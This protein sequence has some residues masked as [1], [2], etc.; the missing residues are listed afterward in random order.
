MIG[1][2]L[3][4]LGSQENQNLTKSYLLADSAG[5]CLG[6]RM[7]CLA[8][9]T[10]KSGAVDSRVS[11]KG[12]CKMSLSLRICAG[13]G[14]LRVIATGEFSLEEAERTFLEILAAVARHKAK[15][16]LLDGRAV[17]GEPKSIQRFL[18]GDFVAHAFMSYMM[19]RP[20]PPAPQFA[21]V[22][23]EPVLDPQRFGETVAVNRGMWVKVFDNLED[24]LGWLRVA[25]ADKPD[26]VDA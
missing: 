8:G 20:V 12:W 13:S 5:D 7:S 23:Q 9:Y 19:E 11:W 25:P 10:A 21:Y 22:L 15:K 6:F 18:Y 1:F 24:A 17:R 14:L 16:I 3:T 26:A 2:H 4:W